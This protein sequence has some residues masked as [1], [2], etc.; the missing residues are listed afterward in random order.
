MPEGLEVSLAEAGA[1]EAVSLKISWELRKDSIFATFYKQLSL[2]NDDLNNSQTLE[3]H[4]CPAAARARS[5]ALNSK[6]SHEPLEAIS[7]RAE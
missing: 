6:G 3:T 1:G 5:Q 4:G 7:P 2:Q